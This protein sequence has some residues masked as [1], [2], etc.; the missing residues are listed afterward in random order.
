MYSPA[1]TSLSKVGMSPIQ[2]AAQNGSVDVILALHRIGG[3]GEFF[4]LFAKRDF[5]LDDKE[6]YLVLRPFIS[7]FEWMICSKNS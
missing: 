6:H 2:W 3:D 7:F 5:S 1:N 4:F